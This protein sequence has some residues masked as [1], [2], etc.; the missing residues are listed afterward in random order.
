MDKV[1]IEIQNGKKG[2]EP[3]VLD[4]IQWETERKGSPGKLTLKVLQDSKL[5]IEEGN[6]LS[7]K[8]GKTKVFYGYIF[9]RSMDK[10]NILNLTCYDQ[11]RYLKNKDTYSFENTTSN[12]IT[13]AI[14][15]DYGIRTGELEETA[16]VIKAVVYD[17]KTLIDMIQDSLDMTLTNT[18]KLYVLYDKY[19]KLTIQRIDRM[20]VGLIIDAD[21]AETFEY[22]VD[23]DDETYNR[24][25]LEYEDSDTHNRQFWTAEDKKTQKKWGTL[26][27]F[28]SISKDEKDSAQS[29]A[30]SLLELYN[31]PKKKLTITNAIGDLRVRGG[32]MVLV[33][34]DIGQEKISHWMV[35]DKCTHIFKQNEHFMTLELIGGGFVG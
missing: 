6:T 15:K 13:A 7:F 28:E 9:K 12:R 34:M 4:D 29:K 3:V 10:T 27:Y 35:V 21:T 23:I 24:V 5:N 26:Q 17:N 11:I 16:F 8:L 32:S 2:F 22:S 18:K 14:A 31:L 1:Y 19:G 20:K 33:Q 30:N 25:K